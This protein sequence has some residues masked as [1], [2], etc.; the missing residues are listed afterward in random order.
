MK[1]WIVGIVI[2]VLGLGEYVFVNVA[3]Y[4]PEKRMW[5][6][7]QIPVVRD[8]VSAWQVIKYEKWSK[9]GNPWASAI[10]YEEGQRREDDALMARAK[11]RLLESDT[12]A[13]RY[14]L[15]CIEH[16]NRIDGDGVEW[17]V[18]LL[19]AGEENIPNPMWSSEE[20]RSSQ[21]KLDTWRD[22]IYLRA[23]S[24][25]KR[26]QRIVDGLKE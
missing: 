14:A 10:L 13:A 21:K 7:R 26:A 8:V 24:G 11:K 6:A 23:E 12:H 1:Y 9:E 18:L 25:N 2:A 20:A 22:G 3:P 15:Y 4:P 19:K 17:S 16:E 5:R